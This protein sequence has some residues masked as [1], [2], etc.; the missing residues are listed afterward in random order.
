MARK[1]NQNATYTRWLVAS[2]YWLA[3]HGEH[4]RS[5]VVPAA[6][7]TNSPDWQTEMAEHSRLELPVFALDSHWVAALHFLAEV[8]IRSLESVGAFDSNSPCSQTS[9]STHAGS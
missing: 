4:V 2:W 7:L 5:F 1:S 9:T 8:Q 6:L 3:P